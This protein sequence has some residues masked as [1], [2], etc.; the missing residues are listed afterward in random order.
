MVKGT[1]CR[2]VLLCCL[3]TAERAGTVIRRR[4]GGMCPEQGC[5]DPLL[6]AP[7][8]SSVEQLE[9]HRLYSGTLAV[10]GWVH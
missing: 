2:T 6:S 3:I 7:G 1:N 8:T 5:P 4:V 10:T 9:E